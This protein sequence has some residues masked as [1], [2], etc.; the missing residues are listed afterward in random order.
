MRKV[1]MGTALALSLAFAGTAQAVTP[2]DFENFD[3]FN[4]G[5]GVGGQGSWLA[6]GPAPYNYDQ[7]IVEVAGGKAL[8]IS[9]AV[10]NGEFH[11]MPY[12]APVER[13]GEN[14]VNNVLVNEFTFKS[15]SP[16]HQQPGL[17]M[18][19]S[20]T[21]YDGDR[22]S[23]IR[24][25][26]RFDGVRVIF[27][28]ATF[29]DQ[30]IA[31]L[32]RE[33]SH[34]IKFHTTF[35]KGNDNDVVRVFIDGKQ[36][37]Y[38]KSWENYYRFGTEQPQRNPLPSD[39]LMWRLGGGTV[40]AAP[41]TLGKGFLFDN[42]KSTSSHVDNPDPYSP[43]AGPQGAEGPQGATGAQGATGLQ[44]PKGDQGPAGPVAASNAEA[45][46]VAG[47]P[48]RG[49]VSIAS[50][51]LAVSKSGKVRVKVE[52]SGAGLHR[53][54]VLLRSGGKIVG[55]GKFTVRGGDTAKVSVRLSKRALQQVQAG[56]LKKVRAYVFSGDTTAHAAEST[57]SLSI[58]A[59]G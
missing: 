26:D 43:L 22:M 3:N 35:V 29:T 24:L 6:G 7:E 47:G 36:K 4:A 59:R 16:D 34:E 45:S 31:T 48:Q 2:T 9:N 44:G 33:Q 57:R 1:M 51:N 14:E 39:R 11:H 30:W 25:E 18:A 19:I 58:T 53:G 46:V 12:S 5:V 55:R 13:A 54:R 52:S 27:T 15:F 38:G 40:P 41:N 28:D 56:S 23:Y 50:R 37:M 32:D 42:V 10:V 17:A 8:R 20:P 49:S 21:S